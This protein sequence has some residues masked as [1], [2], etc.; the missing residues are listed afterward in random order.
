MEQSGRCGNLNGELSCLL[1]SNR[2]IQEDGPPSSIGE[3]CR[4]GKGAL[5]RRFDLDTGWNSLRLKRKQDLVNGHWSR[6]RRSKSREMGRSTKEPMESERGRVS[7]GGD[8]VRGA[9]E[10]GKHDSHSRNIDRGVSRP[11]SSRTGL[12]DC[13]MCGRDNVRDWRSRSACSAYG[14]NH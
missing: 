4:G 7:Q 6:R 2:R 1:P 5:D 8:R 12:P 11:S 10:S 14:A 13:S 3:A 9:S